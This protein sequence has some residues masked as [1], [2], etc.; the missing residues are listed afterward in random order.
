M[1]V[2]KMG[3]DIKFWRCKRNFKYNNFVSL[4]K[5]VSLKK[6]A[7]YDSRKGSIHYLL[8]NKFYIATNIV[9]KWSF[10]SYLTNRNGDRYG[11]F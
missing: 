10:L 7:S 11:S 3:I 5:A 8:R 2:K 9:P 1:Q 4:T 6:N